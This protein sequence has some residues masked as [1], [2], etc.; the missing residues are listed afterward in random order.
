MASGAVGIV[1][2]SRLATG[3]QDDLRLEIHGSRGAL[4]FSLMNP[5]WL[6]AYDATRP[7]AA[8]GGE[9]GFQ[10]IE[11][12][13]RYPKPYAFAA[14]KNTIGWPQFHVHCLYEF[15]RAVAEGGGGGASFADG[16][17]TQRVVD[18]CLRSAAADGWAKIAP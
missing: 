12:A 8:L 9:R 10:Q 15:V 7:E 2:A 13:T 5:N 6:R 18:A 17:A 3:T 4:S 11:C 14:A 1:E 16:L